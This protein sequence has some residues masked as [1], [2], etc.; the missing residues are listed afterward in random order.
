MYI[1]YIE[2]LLREANVAI[3]N[4]EFEKARDMMCDMLFDAPDYA[5]I[6]NNLGWLYQYRIEDKEQA[7][8]HLK[9]A[10]RFDGK[11]ESAYF[12]LSELYIENEEYEKLREVMEAALKAPGVNKSLAYENLGKSHEAMKSYSKAIRC[13]KNALY[14]T[15]DSY[16]ADEMKGNIKRC[17]YK[18][19]KTI[20]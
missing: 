3:D 17:K 7:E 11:M 2:K 15:V 18:R 14:A 19:L 1:E 16:D 9:Y 8:L 13:Y 12:N 20:F 5:K 6:H 4:G 10:I